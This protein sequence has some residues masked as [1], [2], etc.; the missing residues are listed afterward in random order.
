MRNKKV[1]N[2]W[3]GETVICVASG[4]SLTDTDCRTAEKAQEQQ[5]AKIIVINDNYK[6]IKNADVLYACDNRW[7]QAHINKLGDFSGELWSP[8]VNACKKYEQ[9]N[10]IYGE[11][12]EG[13]AKDKIIYGGNS[14]YQAICLAYLF[15]ASKVLLLG[16]DM[17]I[18]EGKS[19][20][21]GDHPAGLQVPSPFA[22]WLTYFNK[23]A[24]DAEQAGLKII[25]CTRKTAL[26][27][28]EMSTIDKCL[29]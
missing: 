17:S 25:N 21:F 3:A 6:K 13:L 19:H 14:G 10:Y 11:H 23:L 29:K 16:Y 18:S 28:F 5:K 7:W 9:I 22:K 8:D 27:C 1:F 26:T 12:G 4:G 24:L 2:R 15:G 20:W